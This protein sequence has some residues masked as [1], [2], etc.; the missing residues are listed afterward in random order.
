MKRKIFASMALGSVTFLGCDMESS[1][2]PAAPQP[3]STVTLDDV[4]RDAATSLETGASYTAQQKEKVMQDLNAQ[5]A[6]M[7]ENIDKLRLKGKDLAGD[8]KTEW[9]RKMSDLEAKRKLARDRIEEFGNSTSEA[10]SDVE[11]GAKAAWED[12]SEAFVKA[13]KEF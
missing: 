6:V 13:S 1:K 8:A 5:M 12:L 2:P 3:A 11:K 9:D 10:W 7:N 4:K